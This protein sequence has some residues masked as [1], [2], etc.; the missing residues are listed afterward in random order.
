MRPSTSFPRNIHVCFTTNG[1]TASFYN[2]SPSFGDERHS[3]AA[4]E[5]LYGTVERLSLQGGVVIV[6]DDNFYHTRIISLL[7]TKISPSTRLLLKKAL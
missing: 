7:G 2:I 4:I 5:G 6:H 1:S 3:G